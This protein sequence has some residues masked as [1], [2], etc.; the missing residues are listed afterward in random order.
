MTKAGARVITPTEEFYVEVNEILTMIQTTAVKLAHKKSDCKEVVR[1]L[2]EIL[3]KQEEN[4]GN[5]AYFQYD[6]EFHKVFVTYSGNE[7]LKDLFK[8]Y[9]VLHEVLVRHIYLKAF[10]E[11]QRECILRHREIVDAFER[12]DV[13][14]AI[15]LME[16]HYRGVEHIFRNAE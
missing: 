12:G 13:Q 1:A 7:R 8:V 14:L 4:I 2:R 9:N 3:P 11:N 15:D 5:E 16:G 10:E 6:Y